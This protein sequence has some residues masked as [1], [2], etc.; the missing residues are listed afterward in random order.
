MVMRMQGEVARIRR[1]VVSGGLVAGFAVIGAL[2][3]TIL[4]DSAAA[5]VLHI[6]VDVSIR[7]LAI[8]FVLFGLC[9]GLFAACV[10]C[11]LRAV[12]SFLHRWRYAIAAG[13]VAL[14]VLLDVNGSSLNSWNVLF[15]GSAQS[16]VVYGR[17]QILRSDEYAVGTP[18]AFAQAYNDYGYFNS[19]V[20]GRP[21][22]MFIVKDAPVLAMA[23]IFRPFHWGY[24]L[25]GSSRGLSFYWFARLVMLFLASYEFG[26]LICSR[27]RYLAVTGAVVITFS[28]LV[29]WW[30]AVNSLPEML[31]AVFLSIVTLH[32]YIDDTNGWHRL[33]YAALIGEFAGIFV[34]SLYPA[35]QI[36]LCYVLL[37]LIIWTLASRW[38]DIRMTRRDA[39]GALVIAAIVCA[40]LGTVVYRSWPTIEATMNTAY[41]GKRV[42][43]GGGLPLAGLIDGFSSIGYAFKSYVGALN[44]SETASMVDLFPLGILLFV[45]AE[46]RSRRRDLLSWLFAGCGTLFFVYMMVG[47]PAVVAKA[48]LLSMSTSTRCHMAFSIVNILLAIRGLSRLHAAGTGVFDMTTVTE[49]DRPS[50]WRSVMAKRM[51]CLAV[52]CGYA[53]LATAMSRKSNTAYVGMKV[54]FAIVTVAFVWCLALATLRTA[55]GKRLWAVAVACMTVSGMSVNPIQYSVGAITDHP[56]IRDTAAA[57]SDSGLWIA[58]SDENERGSML[59]QLLVANGT[60]TLNAVQVTPNMPMWRKLDPTGRWMDVYNRYAYVTVNIVHD[61]ST[62][63]FRLLAPDHISVNLTPDDLTALGASY[64][65]TQRKLSDEDFG[66]YRFAPLSTD[67]TGW[68]AYRL[69][70][71]K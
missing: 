53:V 33:G 63:K 50:V 11:G 61:D 64:V 15:G 4:Y 59:A 19:I 29:Q 60:P 41:P 10:V 45:F 39:L 22:D 7:M 31:I 69:T 58:G 51:A 3:A 47:L 37:A 66:D 25:L 18:F 68:T 24:L 42:S 32:R 9:C 1:Q 71:G 17:P 54:A 27:S 65:L 5:R 57:R 48:T 34:L 20:G 28:P 62:E 12:G 40:L 70:S 52:I 38:R 16:D 56:I 30:F 14:V 55:W 21:S 67:S 43:T 49:A 8:R 26:L 46:I 35:W 23:E 44:S 36:P 13:L 6:A 2:T